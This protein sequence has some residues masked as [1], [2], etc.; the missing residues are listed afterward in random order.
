MNAPNPTRVIVGIDGSEQALAAVRAA[1]A[2]AHHRHEP[3]HIVHAFIWPSLHVNV[4]PVAD[5][6]PRTGLRHHAEDILAEAVAEAGKVA[7]QVPVTTALIDGSATPV[8]LEESHRASLLV[9]GDRGMGGISSVIIGSVAVHAAAH[10]RCAVLVIRGAEPAIGPIVVGVDGS[11][12]AGLAVGFAFEE[13]AHRGAELVPVL[14][15]NDSTSG[16]REW[17]APGRLAAAIEQ[18]ARRTLSESLAGW[19]ER[20]PDV[21][22]R[23]ALV[24]GHPRGALVEYSKTAQLMVLGSRGRDAF[25]GLLLG[26]VSQTLLHNSACP[27]AVIPSTSFSHRLG[28]G[29]SFPG[30]PSEN[31]DQFINRPVN[32][33]ISLIPDRQRVEE[34]LD[35]LRAAGTDVSDVVVLHGPEGVRILDTDGTEHG[36]R[37]RFVRFFQNWG[38][39][40]AVLNLYDEGLRKGESAVMIPSTQEDKAA[41]ARLL[42]QHQGHAIHYFGV[43]SAES[44]S[45]P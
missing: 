41:L 14:V 36:G 6:L 4:G 7:P 29:T 21:V 34:T 24:H 15:W 27:V 42:R 9:L 3:L 30:Q 18:A 22:V 2:E 31:V 35:A 44:L 12:A 37:A 25:Q 23:P 20:Y 38:Y 17:D 5:D 45:G 13:C 26:S 32:A 40:D 16:A 8:L 10:A 43:Q 39:D 33:V 11:E 1:A 28:G 19:R